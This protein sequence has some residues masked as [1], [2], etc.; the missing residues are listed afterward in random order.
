MAEFEFQSRGIG[1]ETSRGCFVCAGGSELRSNLAAFVKSREDGEA[2]VRLFGRGTHF[3]YRPFEPNWLQVKV[4]LA[5]T[6]SRLL[7]DCGGSPRRTTILAL[8]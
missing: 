2:I 4:G 3:D 6:M 7:R 1:L 8:S 5:K